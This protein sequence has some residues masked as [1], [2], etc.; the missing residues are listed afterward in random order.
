MFQDFSV[1]N[2]QECHYSNLRSKKQREILTE[3]SSVTIGHK[4]IGQRG[5]LQCNMDNQW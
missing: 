1:H 4:H 5:Y 3:L 2:I